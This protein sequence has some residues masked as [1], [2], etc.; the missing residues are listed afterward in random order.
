LI[1]N[2]IQTGTVRAFVN[3]RICEMTYPVLQVQTFHHSG[4]EFNRII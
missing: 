4:G 3:A 2:D 1:I